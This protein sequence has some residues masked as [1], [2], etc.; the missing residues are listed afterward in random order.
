MPTVGDR[1]RDLAEATNPSISA[2]S[3]I[4]DGGDFKITRDGFRE[5]LNVPPGPGAFTTLS[6]SGTSTLVGNVAVGAQG[7]L[8]QGTETPTKINL[9][10][11]FGSSLVWNASSDNNIKLALYDDGT[12]RLG[13]GVS[14]GVFSTHVFSGGVAYWYFGGTERMKLDSSGNVTFSG[15]YLQGVEIAAPSAP[16]ANGF[17]IFAEDNGSGKTRLMVQFATG[18]AQQIAIEP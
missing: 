8:G 12:N 16:A 3:Y 1:V 4:V 11:T 18:A 10:I 5:W 17:R 2:F 13:F 7:I 14:N 15:G 9:G 6:A